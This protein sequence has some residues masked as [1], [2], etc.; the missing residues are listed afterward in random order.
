MSVSQS[1]SP[2]VYAKFMYLAQVVRSLELFPSL[3]PLEERLL[4]QLA[5]LWAVD[6]KVT[7]LDALALQPELAP[8]AVYRCLN[9]L[10]QKGLLQLEGE[11]TEQPSRYLAATPMAEKYFARLAQCMQTAARC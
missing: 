6:G 10:R 1:K 3:D 8:G 9:S 5:A 4:N 11:Q 7:V 2:S